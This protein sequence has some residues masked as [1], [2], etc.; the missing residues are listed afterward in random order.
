MSRRSKK[1]HKKKLTLS[2]RDRKRPKKKSKR[3][4]KRSKRSGRRLVNTLLTGL[5]QK[6]KTLRRR[7][8]KGLRESLP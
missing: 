4:K 6:G 3:K 8:R 2:K 5:F 1:H 7:S